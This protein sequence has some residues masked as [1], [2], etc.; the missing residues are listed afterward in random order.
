MAKPRMQALTSF[1]C[2]NLWESGA[3]L[4]PLDQGML[5][6]GAALPDAPEETLADWPLGR[7][8][9]ALAQLRCA[10]FGPRLLGWTACSRCGEKLE[11][12]F[13]ARLLSDDAAN[14]GPGLEEPIVVNGR[15]FRLPTTRDLANAARETD[16]RRAAIRLV[17]S[18]HL[19]AEGSAAWSDEDLEQIGQKFALADPLAETRLTLRC[20]VCENEWEENLDIVSFLWREIE[21]RARKLLFEIHALASAY[22]WTEADIL[23]LSDRR[24]TLYLELAQS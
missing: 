8:N 15:S 18:C 14:Q 6:L 19:N 12:E 3:G 22:G 9:M 24:R 2:L 10:S 7:R 16:A 5:A 13:D 1:N 4:H 23:S 20:P 21:A 17:E 11:V